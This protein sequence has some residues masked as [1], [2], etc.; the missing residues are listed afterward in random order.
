MRK[1]SILFV[2]LMWGL[3]TVSA[4]SKLGLKFSPLLSTSRTSLV[5]TAYNVE[6]AGP[7][8]KFSIGLIFDYEITDTYYFSTGLILLPKQFAV[9]FSTEDGGPLPAGI[10][11]TEAYRTNYLQLPL[12]LKL[13]T[14]EVQPDMRIFFQVGG[15]AEIKVFDEPKE[16]EYVLIEEFSLFD[17]AALL[18]AGAEYR[19]G[20]NTVL[21]GQL[22]YQRGLLNQV[23]TLNNFQFQEELFVRN[24]V[25][26]LDLGIKF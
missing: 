7:G 5:D 6:S 24:T 25:V 17:F 16:E 4:Q 1:K 8:I 19:V 13:F 10:Q 18:G 12:S 23:K 9:D 2:C 22:T 15:A 20:L 26:S 21:F 14:N 11:S 3:L